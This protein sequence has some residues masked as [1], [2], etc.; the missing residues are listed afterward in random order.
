ML[1]PYVE[2][3]PLYNAANFNWNCCFSSTQ[4]D[5]INTTVRNTRI[6][7]FLCPSDGMRGPAEHQQLLRQ[8][9]DVD[10][11]IPGGREHDRGVPC[12]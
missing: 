7:S 10:D 8:H 1:L 11:S 12:L 4:G 6:A 5:R 9:R 3:A 2:Q